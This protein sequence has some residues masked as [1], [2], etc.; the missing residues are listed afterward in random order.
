MFKR[1]LFLILAGSLIMTSAAC[2]VEEDDPAAVDCEAT[3]EDEACQ[4][5]DCEATPDD[6]ACA[7]DCEATPD[8]PACEEEVDCEAMPE[9]EDCQEPEPQFR[10]VLIS[11]LTEGVSGEYP[12][13]DLDAIGLIKDGN[14]TY[15]TAIEG[16]N[17]PADG[18]SAAD[19]SGA[20]GAPNFDCSDGA[21][22]DPTTFT[23][24]GGKEAGG[25]LIGSFGTED[26]DITIEAGDTLKVYEVGKECN[27]RYD[28]DEW[29]LSIAT[30]NDLDSF[31][32]QGELAQGSGT[33]EIMITASE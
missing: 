3:P 7:V 21:D 6:P 2:E 8:D 13:T 19:S 17:I 28:D 27:D 1:S 10:F 29:S 15:L 14:E 23:A 16:A 25:Y 31:T 22:I 24:L 9:H 11:D 18:N 30:G 33:A 4:E 32:E 12:G 20:V 26:E 5:V